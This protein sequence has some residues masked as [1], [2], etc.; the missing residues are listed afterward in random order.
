M[1]ITPLFPTASH[2]T[3]ARAA[4]PIRGSRFIRVAPARRSIS[5]FAPGHARLVTVNLTVD[6]IAAAKQGQWLEIR[7]KV[8]R[9]G[10]TLCFATAEVFS[11]ETFCARAN[12]I[13]R[14]T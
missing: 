1:K 5:D 14:V 9:T 10:A 4:L 11:D 6:F 8:V 7:P 3:G 13:F 2:R 12:A